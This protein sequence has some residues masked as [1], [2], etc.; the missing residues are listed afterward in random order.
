[1]KWLCL[2]NNNIGNEGAIALEKA[3]KTREDLYIYY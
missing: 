1:L 2:E 3:K